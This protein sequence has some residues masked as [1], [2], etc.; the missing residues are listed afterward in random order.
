L[1]L[2]GEIIDIYRERIF[3]VNP[4][5]S[6]GVCNP[7]V[8][9]G[10]SSDAGWIATLKETFFVAVLDFSV[11]SEVPFT[12]NW[13]D[14]MEA[15][16]EGI[17][18]K[19]LTER[20]HSRIPRWRKNVK[21]WLCNY[22]GTQSLCLSLHTGELRFSTTSFTLQNQEHHQQNVYGANQT[23]GCTESW[24]MPNQGAAKS[25][26]GIIGSYIF[27]SRRRAQFSSFLYG[28]QR[29][30][31]SDSGKTSLYYHQTP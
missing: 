24:W 30:V 17:K 21:Q 8:R 22:R 18:I 20:S 23:K 25:A 13:M 4:V 16:T 27:L 28:S 14:S 5:E 31:L 10:E 11:L 6:V 1:L 9:T 2:L 7:L 26:S 3:W 19:T 29:N 12:I 15:G